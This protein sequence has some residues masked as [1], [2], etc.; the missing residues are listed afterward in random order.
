MSGNKTAVHLPETASEEE[1]RAA[2]AQG[3]ARW[4]A[5]KPR[6]DLLPPDA[7]FSLVGVF[8]HGCIKYAERNW[9]RGMDWGICFGAAQRH[10]WKWWNG[11][12]FDEDSGLSHL[13]HAM[14]NCMVLEAYRQRGMVQ[15]DD[16]PRFP[17]EPV[18]TFLPQ[19]DSKPLL[20]RF[21]EKCR[22]ILHWPKSKS[23]PVQ[24]A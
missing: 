8:D 17:M 21:A 18:V 3:G 19:E 20:G 24:T 15:F 5:G 1:K 16:R 6:F 14:W 7:L 11:E 9:E 13:A 10:L 23:N 2:L 12:E 22:K 4:N